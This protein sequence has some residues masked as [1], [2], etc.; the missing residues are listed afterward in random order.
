MAGFV[1]IGRALS[2][3][4]DSLTKF[5]EATSADLAVAG[6]AAVSTLYNTAVGSGEVGG[7]A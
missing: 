3:L 1:C 6:S 5:L 4:N 2:L 7:V